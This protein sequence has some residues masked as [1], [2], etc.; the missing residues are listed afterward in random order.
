MGRPYPSQ[1]SVMSPG[2]G[3]RILTKYR[4][5]K[6]STGEALKGFC[7]F[8]PLPVTLCPSSWL[9]GAEVLFTYLFNLFKGCTCGVWS[10]PGL[11]SNWNC[12]RWSHWSDVTATATWDLSRVCDL[13]HSLC[14]C[15]ILNP[16]SEARHQTCVLMDASQICFHWTMMGTPLGSF[17]N[18]HIIDWRC[19]LRFTLVL[20]NIL[21]VGEEEVK[22]LAVPYC[23]EFELRTGREEICSSVATCLP[24]IVP[25]EQP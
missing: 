2:A 1:P 12:S 23:R 25:S 5:T 20:L 24:F 3:V 9:R 14:Q 8:C 22:M 7:C 10:F 16:L 13:H 6:E 11:G 18:G 17:L 19:C 15:W 21:Y 4:T